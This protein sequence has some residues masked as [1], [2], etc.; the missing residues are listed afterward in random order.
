MDGQRSKDEQFHVERSGGTLHTPVVRCTVRVRQPH[1]HT[2]SAMQATVSP[3]S[4]LTLCVRNKVDSY[5]LTPHMSV[6]P[7]KQQETEQCKYP[8][9]QGQ[10]ALCLSLERVMF[11]S[12]LTRV[13][14]EGQG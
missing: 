8:G 14:A 5:L 3:S 2:D 13:G 9:L 4:L 1:R 7:P 6:V 10:T 11:T 12:P